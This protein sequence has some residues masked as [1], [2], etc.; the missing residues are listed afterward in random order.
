MIIEEKERLKF[1]EFYKETDECIN[2]KF[3]NNS[4]YANYQV[5]TNRI[6]RHVLMHRVAYQLHYNDIIETSDVICHKCDNPACINPKHLFKGTHK[7]NSDDKLSKGRQ[8]KG[9][10]NGRYTHGYNSKF[11]PVAKPLQPFDK[12]YNRLLTEEQVK[13]IKLAIKNRGNTSLKE[14]SEI[15]DISYVNIRAISSGKAYK[16]VNIT[17]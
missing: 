15:F 14:L 2:F 1:L 8:A 9:K 3:L 5:T 17:L 13:T 4:G 7:S 10:T 11:D 6:K 16:N 12:R